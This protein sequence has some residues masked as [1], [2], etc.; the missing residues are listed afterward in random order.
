MYAVIQVGGRQY[1]VQ[2]GQELEVDFR[3]V[4]PGEKLQFD[5]VL[6]IND[7]HELRTGTPTVPG[8]IVSASVVGAVLG[9]KIY[10]QKLRRRKNSRRR[11]GH[12]QI[13][14][15]VRIEKIGV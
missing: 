5:Q 8:A 6:A 9:D 7:D 14:T 12:R 11:T 10:I 3:D 2:E 4:E 13:F 15:K 1:R